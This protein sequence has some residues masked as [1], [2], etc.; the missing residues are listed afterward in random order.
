MI[1]C[2]PPYIPSGDIASLDRT[3]RDF[4]PVEALDGGPDGLAFYRSVTRHWK[5]VL[6]E[7]G[8]IAFECGAGQAGAVT[9]ILCENGFGA[10]KTRQDTLK[11]DRV[12]IGTL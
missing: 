1:V 8:R 7:G 2:N 11:I 3:V 5:S 6:K 9:G 4:E 12:V 10:V